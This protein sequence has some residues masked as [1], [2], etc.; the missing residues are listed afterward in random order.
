MRLQPQLVGIGRRLPAWRG[1]ACR[2]GEFFIGAQSLFG[3]RG[4]KRLLEHAQHAAEGFGCDR[5]AGQGCA[6]LR[7]PRRQQFAA[8]QRGS[9]V[10]A[11]RA[12]LQFGGPLRRAPRRTA[13]QF[14]RV[15][16][17]L[18]RRD[19]IDALSGVVEL[20]DVPRRLDHHCVGEPAQF[21]RL[22]QHTQQ[23]AVRCR[24]QPGGAERAANDGR[25]FAADA[26]EVLR[27][28]VHMFY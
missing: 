14:V 11:A 20:D 12:A 23:F 19:P 24:G 21:G 25:Q 5:P 3:R 16:A 15:A 28:I 27:N 26:V 7:E 18:L 13:Q 9:A 6:Q 22:G 17:S 8:G 2:R 1:A 4:G 10:H